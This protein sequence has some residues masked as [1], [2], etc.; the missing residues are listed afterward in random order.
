M[1]RHWQR[2]SVRGTWGQQVRDRQEQT[3]ALARRAFCPVCGRKGR[4]PAY[5][6]R[7]AKVRFLGLSEPNLRYSEETLNLV[8]LHNLPSDAAI[9]WICTYCERGVEYRRGIGSSRTI[10][11]TNPHRVPRPLNMTSI[12]I[13]LAVCHL[14]A[15]R[16]MRE[17]K[18][19]RG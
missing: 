17:A 15:T 11:R 9:R 16:L 19:A 2:P 5:G 1:S 18:R 13:Q 10:A 4:P 12:M 6:V 8:E 3:K 7:Q 14:L